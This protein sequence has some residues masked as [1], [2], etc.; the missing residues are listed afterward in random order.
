MTERVHSAFPASPE[1]QTVVPAGFV[2]EV[3]GLVTWEIHGRS[4]QDMINGELRFRIG[5]PTPRLLRFCELAGQW[6]HQFH[7]LDLANEGDYGTLSQTTFNGVSKRS[8]EP[9]AAEFQERSSP[10]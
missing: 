5:A 3:N 10:P 7:S 6:L 9:P 4:L 2:E 1:L 8:S